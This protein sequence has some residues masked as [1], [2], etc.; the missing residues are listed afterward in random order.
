[1]STSSY[2]RDLKLEAERMG[3]TIGQTKNNH[4]KITHPKVVSPIFASGTP[5]DQR[6]LKN[7]VAKMAR[8]LR[9]SGVSV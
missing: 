2:L 6:V 7:V 4:L 9:Q 1:M 3:Y 8:M 5:S